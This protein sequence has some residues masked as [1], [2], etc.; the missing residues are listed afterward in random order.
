MTLNYWRRNNFTTSPKMVTADQLACDA[1][2]Q[3]EVSWTFTLNFSVAWKGV[4]LV[5]LQS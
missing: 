3:M 5:S 2:V 1:L 4:S